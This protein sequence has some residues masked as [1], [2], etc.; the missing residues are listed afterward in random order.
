MRLVPP[1]PSSTLH[2]ARRLALSAGMHYVYTGNVHDPAGGST[3]CPSCGDVVL[4]RDWYDI[5][6]CHLTPGTG[7]AGTCSACGGT[8][9]GVFDGPVGTWGTRRLPVHLA[10]DRSAS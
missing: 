3:T 8:V 7:G 2:D 4:A 9:A 5:T 1:T 10:T 6:G